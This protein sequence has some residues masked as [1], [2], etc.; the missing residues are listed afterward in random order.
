MTESSNRWALILAGGAGT[1]LSALT[2]TRGGGHVPKQYCSLNG[3]PSL[4][5]DTVARAKALV[6]EHRV[7]AVVAAEHRRYW[8][9]G[10]LGMRSE[11]LVVQPSN[12][13]TATGILLGAAA[14]FERDPSASVALLP[15]DHHVTQ[16]SVLRASLE[17]ALKAVDDEQVPITLLGVRP[18]H[19]DPELGYIVRGAPLRDGGF[20]IARFVEK[21]G[22]A[23][24]AALVAQ[25]ALW[26][27][28]IVA[29]RVRALLDLIA[30]RY[31]TVVQSVLDLTS[32]N[33]SEL[34]LRRVYDRLPSIDFS[35]DVVEGADVPLAVLPVPSCGWSDLGTPT[36][37]AE[38]LE[39][40][41][42]RRPVDR[43]ARS[44]VPRPS[45][46]DAHAASLRIDD[47]R[48]HMPH[49]A[50]AAVQIA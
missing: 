38:C 50:A 17:R 26:N 37:L 7:V 5:E 31:P 8:R 35:R 24:A 40:I 30:R 1:R 10:I 45:L 46:A 25:S 28:F 41:G 39:H 32:R 43:L 14:I 49:A 9:G 11:N 36:R 34:E 27:V 12:R 47:T 22:S 42:A 44:T 4:I 2:T 48:R 15:A 16:E 23:D 19:A 6:P 3:G 20:H 18:D 21:P 33:G 29:A 13:G